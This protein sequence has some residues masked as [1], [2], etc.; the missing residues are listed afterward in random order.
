MSNPIPLRE[1]RKTPGRRVLPVSHLAWVL[2]DGTRGATGDDVAP[3]RATARRVWPHYRRR[4][5]ARTCVGL[6]PAAAKIHD[7]ISTSGWDELWAT[8]RST[9]FSLDAVLQGLDADRASVE[10]FERRD[11]KGAKDIAD[12]LA[13]FRRYLDRV[14]VAARES[15]AMV[16]DRWRASM[17]TIPTGGRYGTTEER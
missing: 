14:E 13:Q 12:Y 9:S 1:V 7:E 5:W 2:S 3:D 6:V 17:P 10:A 8:W 15:G 16:T 4:V 11:P